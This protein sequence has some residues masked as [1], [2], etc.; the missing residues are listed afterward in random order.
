M[1]SGGVRMKTTRQQDN[2]TTRT[3]AVGCWLLVAGFWLLAFGFWLNSNRNISMRFFTIDSNGL[4]ST[5]SPKQWQ[6]SSLRNIA[7][8]IKNKVNNIND[9]NARRQVI[10]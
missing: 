3:L 5:S 4:N 9:I 8:Y 10:L 7:T 1:E 6:L 2:K